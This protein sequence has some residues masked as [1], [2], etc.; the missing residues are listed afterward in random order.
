MQHF[1]LEV[2][3]KSLP[4]EFM[5][6]YCPFDDTFRFLASY[7]F[8]SK[9]HQSQNHPNIRTFVVCGNTTV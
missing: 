6:H 7:A 9:P 5:S 4:G 8:G 2:P 1:S 3:G